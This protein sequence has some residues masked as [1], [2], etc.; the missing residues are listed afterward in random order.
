MEGLPGKSTKAFSG[1]VDM[2]S[3]DR[4]VGYTSVYL[5]QIDLTVYLKIKHFTEHKIDLMYL[6]FLKM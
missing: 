6:I 5:Y 2:L 3:L 1:V 4:E